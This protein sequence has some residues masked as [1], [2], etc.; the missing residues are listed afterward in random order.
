M[1]SILKNTTVL[2]VTASLGMTAMWYP[3]FAVAQESAAAEAAQTETER[4]NAWFEAKHKEHLERSPMAKTARGIIGEDYGRWDDNSPEREQED[5]ERSQAELTEMISS[6]DYDRLDDEGKLSWRLFEYRKEQERARWPYRDYLYIFNQIFGLHVTA[7]TFLIN[8]HRI[9]TEAHA[10][11]YIERL[12]GFGAYLDQGAARAKAA[13]EK[14][15]APPRFVYDYVMDDIDGMLEA[16]PFVKSDVKTPL[17]EDFLKKTEALDL[18]D[19]RKKELEGQARKALLEG[20][21]PAYQRLQDQLARERESATDDAGVWKFPDGAKFYAYRLQNMTTTDMSPDKIHELGLSETKRIH[22][23][24]REI[25]RKTNFEGDLSDFFNFMRTDERF[26]YPD[27]DEGREQYLEDATAIIDEIE[28]RLDELFITLPKAPLEVRA[29]E[30]FREK[31]AAGAFYSAA[32]RDGSRPGV[33]Y[34]NLYD[35]KSVTK[36]GM[37]ALAYHEGLPG[38][39][40]Q[41]SIAQELDDIPEFRKSGGISAYSEG[42]GLYSEWLPKELGLYK[43]PYEDFG[44]LSLEMLRAGRLVVDTGLHHKKWTVEEATDWLVANTPVPRDAARRAIERYVVMPGQA[45]SYKVGML[46][47][48]ELRAR[49]EKALGDDFDLRKFHDLVLRSGAVPLDMLE[50]IVD[51]W[52]EKGGA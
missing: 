35:M 5:Y 36:Y 16:A 44:R 2:V 4:L 51:N 41:I 15:I 14:G 10:E 45:T 37:K 32:S 46:K 21:Y 52:I 47:I 17:W 20:I 40:M 30:K 12:N 48:Q 7:P 25:M 26:R 34:I 27:S 50:D 23:E 24:M 31:T 18:P 6:F 28:G 29:V 13:Y 22:D 19:K 39:H 33:Y 9:S 38:H 43:N 1:K 8:Q 42:W 11:A 49:A 3:A